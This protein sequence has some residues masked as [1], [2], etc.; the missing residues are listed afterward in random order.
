MR[1]MRKR[2]FTLVELVTV[3][4]IIGI[5][6]AIFFSVFL[7]NWT[8]LDGDIERTNLWQDAN[9]II[10][11]ISLDVRIATAIDVSAD[12]KTLTLT[13][14]GG[15]VVY[16]FTSDGR[17]LYTSDATTEVLSE[18]VNYDGSLFEENEAHTSVTVTLDLQKDVLGRNVEVA[19]ST[20]V[21]SRNI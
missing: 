2:G 21:Y 12:G 4:A 5:S 15:D 20:E 9:E 7:L 18:D 13:Q 11:R 14:G 16:S 1:G 19:T 3:V 10:D 6:S 17:C 8:A